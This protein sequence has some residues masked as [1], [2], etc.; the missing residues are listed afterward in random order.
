MP[1][2]LVTGGAGFIGS[3]IVNALV[4]RGERVVVLDNLSTGQ[5]RNLDAVAEKIEFI[6]GDIRDR[7]MLARVTRRVDYIFHEAALSSVPFSISDPIATHENNLEGTLNVLV[8]AVEAKVK[9]VVYAST[10]AV[11]GEKSGLLKRDWRETNPVSP[12]A[13]SKFGAESYCLAYSSYYGLPTVVLRYFNVF[14]PRQSPKS[15]YFGVIPKFITCLLSGK[16]PNINGDG[17][18]SR[19]FVY[20]DDVVNATLFACRRQEAIGKVVDVA[21]GHSHTVL[22]AFA[23]LATLTGSLLQPSFGE[24]LPGEVR[25]SVTSI[26]QMVEIL[27]YKPKIDWVEG[28]KRTINWFSREDNFRE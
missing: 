7:A 20:V 19:D 18:Q 23:D 14:G 16:S 6:E 22:Q 1:N 12:Y 8:A 15:H 25:D 13:A 27:G 21:S 11:Y 10:S 5:R 28:L 4:L 26:E 17:M 24:K 2:F 3:H 9:R